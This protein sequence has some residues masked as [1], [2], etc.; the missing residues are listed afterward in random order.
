[1][2]LRT[3]AFATFLVW[4]LEIGARGVGAYDVP[5]GSLRFS[6]VSATKYGAGRKRRLPNFR[7]SLLSHDLTT[8]G[9]ISGECQTMM[10]TLEAPLI[11]ARVIL[12]RNSAAR[13]LSRE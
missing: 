12:S 5:S 1:M 4:W 9:G 6:L 13:V 3:L 8:N 7:C 11:A 2:R 10:L